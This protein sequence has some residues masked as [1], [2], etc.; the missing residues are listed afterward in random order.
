MDL[1]GQPTITWIHSVSTIMHWIVWL[2]DNYVVLLWICWHPCL[3]SLPT[4]LPTSFHL[5]L[6]RWSSVCLLV[7][8]CCQ[9]LP[10]QLLILH[11]VGLLFIYSSHCFVNSCPLNSC[12]LS[13]ACLVENAHDWSGIQMKMKMV[14]HHGQSGF[15][16]PKFIWVTLVVSLCRIPICRAQLLPL[17]IAQ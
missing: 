15:S 9:V 16:T 4:C 5:K 8:L 6:F 10:S 7:S 11:F 2:M 14:H 1:F 12:P 17:K 3:T 13:R